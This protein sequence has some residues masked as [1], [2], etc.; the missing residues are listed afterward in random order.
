MIQKP[1]LSCYVPVDAGEG[2]ILREWLGILAGVE[3]RLVVVIPDREY[4]DSYQD[5]P[6]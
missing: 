1:Q 2:S 4:P 6:A 5:P 3:L